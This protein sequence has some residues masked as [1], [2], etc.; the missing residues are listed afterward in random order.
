MISIHRQIRVLLE[1]AEQWVETY[2]DPK[3]FTLAEYPMLHKQL[4]EVKQVLK[5]MDAYKRHSD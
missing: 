1:V 5:D 4:E 3:H 2:D